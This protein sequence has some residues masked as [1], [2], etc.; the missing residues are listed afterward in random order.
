MSYIALTTYEMVVR[1]KVNK[2]LNKNF[3]I[4]S[5]SIDPIRN[6]LIRDGEKIDISP[7]QIRILQCLV[8]SDGA[9]VTYDELEK[10]IQDFDKQSQHAAS[11]YQHVAALR[12]ALGDTTQNPT[13]IK[14]ISKQGYQFVGELHFPKTILF[15]NPSEIINKLLL[16]TV[17]LI[18]VIL[19]IVFANYFHSENNNNYEEMVVELTRQ[20][21]NPK[22]I[23]ALQY[24]SQKYQGVEKALQNATEVILKYHLEQKAEQHVAMVPEFSVDGSYE[25]LNKHFS[26]SSEYKY[27]LQPKIVKKD[28]GRFVILSLVDVARNTNKELLKLNITNAPSETVLADFEKAAVKSLQALSLISAEQSTQLNSSTELSGL[29]LDAASISLSERFYHWEELENSIKK[30]HQAIQANPGNVIA[31]T[32]LWDAV[33]LLLDQQSKYNTDKELTLLKEYSIK[34]LLV[35]QQYFKAYHAYAEYFC[36][37]QDYAACVEK[38]AVAMQYNPYDSGV[39]NLLRFTL[40]EAIRKP[41][42][43]VTTKNYDLNPFVINAV[44]FHR[45]ALLSQ[46]KIHQAV[47]LL[48]YHSEWE[49]AE[50]NW[51]V[52]GQTKTQ[53]NEL[54]EFSNWYMVQYSDNYSKFQLPSRYIGYMLLNSNQPE[55]ARYWIENGKEENLPYFDLRVTGMLSDLW[56][57]QWDKTKWQDIHDFAMNRREFQ[58]TLDKL[59]IA[60]FD[61]Y[62]RFYSESGRY[63]EELFP[64]FSEENFKITIDNFRYAVYYNEIKKQLGD[65]RRV[66]YIEHAL[67]NFLK[68]QGSSLKRNVYFGIADVEFYAL[69]GEEEKAVSLLE[70]VVEKQNW[71]PNAFWL[72]PPIEHN[73]FL[74]NLREYPEFKRLS[75]K[76]NKRLHGLCFEP[77]CLQNLA[78]KAQ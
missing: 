22:Q 74:K 35:N 36:R 66:I 19:A 10:Q 4:N 28:T 77:A 1:Y 42:L 25:K 52:V 46:G 8:E 62:A 54:V 70:Q 51:H 23:V 43:D 11:L 49:V 44:P 60:Y 58:N 72:W 47:E 71:L 27:L 14:T 21:S 20:L 67:R 50:K 73:H 75:E 48:A 56:Q 3:F 40:V 41:E 65:H 69:N 29:F 9:L 55:L 18:V 2:K 37:T 38:L 26:K 57:G 59:A 13:F 39:L 16:M 17:P 34:S 31:Y 53:Y 7:K 78:E 30:S 64:Q 12:K 6:F 63:I 32:L 61:Y 15:K 68:E 45:N 76:M 33:F 5:V 24:S